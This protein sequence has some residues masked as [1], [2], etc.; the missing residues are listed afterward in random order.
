M[1][2]EAFD[3]AYQL[4]SKNE[5]Q[6]TAVDTT[7]GPLLVI[8][9]PGTGKTQLLSVRVGK[10][11]QNNPTILP[12][13][14]LCL[15]FTETGASNMRD[16]LTQFI[17]KDA[18]DV[19]ISTYHAFG[20][21]IIRRYSQHFSDMRLQNAIDDLGKYQIVSNI[22]EGLPYD[23]PMKQA[24]YHIGDVISTISDVKRALLTSNDL[25]AIADENE[26]T[27]HQ[28]NDAIAEV[29]KDLKR[30]PPKLEKSLPYFVK[31]REIL[32]QHSPEV[33]VLPKFGGLAAVAVR[34]LDNA[35][36]SAEIQS[37]SKPLTAWKNGWLVKDENNN[38]TL[39]GLFEVERIRAFAGIY[40]TYQ[41]RLMSNGLYDFDDMIL[42]AI[43]LLENNADLKYT[44]QEQYQYILLDEFQDT[45]ASQLRLVQ[46]MTDNPIHEGRPNVMAVG[47]DDQA[48]Y[49]FQG[50]QYS[51]MV[52]FYQMYRDV[53]VVNLTHNYRSHRD[54]LH[55]A[56]NITAQIESRVFTQL[57]NATKQLIAANEALPDAEITRHEFDSDIAQYDWIAAQIEAKIKGGV[58]PREIAVL[59]P[60][61][62][63]LAPLIAY[64]NRRN[65]PVQYE[66]RENIL[67]APLIKQ[68][69]S[70]MRLIDTLAR[71]DIA[72]ANALWPQVLSFA[73]W[74][75]STSTIWRLSWQ[76][77][78]SAAPKNWSQILLENEDKKLRSIALLFLATAQSALTERHEV[79]LD[80]LI[81]NATVN[82]NEED[83]PQVVSP[84]RHY[85]L[86]P[87]IQT[88]S[89]HLF[90]DT[91]SQLT[92][93]RE[94]CRE[95]QAAQDASIT[96]SDILSFIDLYETSGQQML[97]TSPHT[98]HVD[99]VRVMTVFK[100]KGLEFEH[101]FLPSCQDNVW[102]GAGASKRNLLKLPQNLTP[103]RHGGGTDDERL[104][105]FFV[106]VT[107]ARYG[108]HLM[109]YTN[110]YS[111]KTTKRLRYLNE[112]LQEDNS[113]RTL[114]LPE[115]HQIVAP[116]DHTPPTIENLELNWQARHHNF[117]DDVDLFTLLKD[118]LQ[119]Y[120]LSPTDLT[121]FVDVIYAGPMSFFF[122]SLLRF[123][124]APSVDMLFGNA[125]HETLEWIQHNVNE[126]G[127]LPNAEALEQH[128]ERQLTKSR[129][130]KQM[131]QLELARGTKA[132]N[133]FMR[134]RNHIFQQEGKAEVSF[135][136]EN[137]VIDDVLMT[138]KIDRMEIDTENKSITI[139]DY[140]T[141]KSY[142]TLVSD[143]KLHKYTLQLYCYKLMIEHSRTY[144]DYKVK[145]GRLEFVE[146]DKK[147]NINA[148]EIEFNDQET[149]R[150]RHL[151]KKMWQCVHALQLPTIDSY[152]PT[153]TGIK[154][155]EKELLTEK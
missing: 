131:F 152:P 120:R 70:M 7:E 96:I 115:P 39:D 19:T 35:I 20:D 123:P 128:F 139:V 101:V 68:L 155:F 111:G 78:D 3:A 55:I 105:I 65:I 46:L 130:P 37:S 79:V 80:H 87:E 146:P 15:T 90:Y 9:G 149:E 21:E 127:T 106:A 141:G 93:L 30:M 116:T 13:N 102:G 36:E 57:S 129:L 53:E 23:N 18:Y 117:Y 134:Q 31:T 2:S 121:G 41:E 24:R 62:S 64:L 63:Q 81:G 5:G 113:V 48:I 151:L 44:L 61:H 114:I 133:T 52:D 4:I 91:I 58:A 86:S 145:G 144:R 135:R 40:D 137:V 38:F 56:D 84:L 50:A 108:L 69:I 71:N 89:P 83:L 107:R 1:R 66:K 85:Y 10:I 88:T 51:N 33:V 103:I 153:L 28:A 132:L 22:I 118:R 8:A 99:A 43:S 95:H 60:K 74:E 29:F 73:F 148:L 143:P 34:E 125:I 67:D 92:V 27:I 112:Q 124:Q 49:A 17:G 104:R 12:N 82:T 147:G 59:A 77:N 138:G 136:N 11:L 140:K 72:A 154:A 98:Q 14:I 100:A 16:R 42:Q 110:A 126:Y 6:K 32:V 109:S 45:N 26:A 25:R 54:I 94:K 97:N 142:D 119:Q 122:N 150:V 75:I 76:A 47:D